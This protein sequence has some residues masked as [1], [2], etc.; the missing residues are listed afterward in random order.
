[1]LE[2][3]REEDILSAPG[4]RLSGG[5]NCIDENLPQVKVCIK[6]INPIY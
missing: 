1:M 5:G 4:I 6:V 3:V 2:N